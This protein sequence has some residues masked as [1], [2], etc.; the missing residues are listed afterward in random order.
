MSKI[1]IGFLKEACEQSSA[2]YLVFDLS[3]KTTYNKVIF[4]ILP[5]F[6]DKSL[7]CPNVVLVGTNSEK[8]AKILLNSKADK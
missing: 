7:K 2:L 4:T 6:K 5:W 1:D 8:R 3:D